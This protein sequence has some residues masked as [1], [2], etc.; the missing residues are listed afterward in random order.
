MEVRLKSSDGTTRSV[1]VQAMESL[2][3]TTCELSDTV[4][5]KRI[6]DSNCARELENPRKR[7]RS[8]SPLRE[9]EDWVSGEWQ[10]E[11]G[12]EEVW[13]AEGRLE[14][15]WRGEEESED[16]EEDLP[17]GDRMAYIHVGEGGEADLEAQLKGT[18]T[19]E[20]KLDRVGRQILKLR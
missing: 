7:A 4:N 2:D 8:T 1:Q 18:D 19:F 16:S 5:Q 17:P 20:Y 12:R 15:G 13:R 14:E 11:E 3:E 10:G 9:G 6:G